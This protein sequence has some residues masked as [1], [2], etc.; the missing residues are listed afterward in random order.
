MKTKIFGAIV[1]FLTIAAVT[2]N[3]VYLQRTVEK[4]YSQIEAVDMSADGAEDS[5]SAAYAY[6]RK[7][8]KVI[9]LTVNHEDLTAIEEA[10][11]EIEGLLSIKRYEEA[12]V[13]K[14]RLLDSLEH[15]RRLS[16]I[17]FDS[18]M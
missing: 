18:I 10:F 14:N 15:L 1:F 4:I 16:G 11:S 8:E 5:F 3:T 9:N 17:N 13:T 12:E 2:A 7:H 6:F